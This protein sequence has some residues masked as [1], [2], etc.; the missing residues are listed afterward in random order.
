M[1]RLLLILTLVSLT[2][3]PLVA[4]EPE[5]SGDPDEGYCVVLAPGHMPP[6]AIDPEECEIPVDAVD[7]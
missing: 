4:A 6:A 1:M 2:A 5:S 7:P 3:A